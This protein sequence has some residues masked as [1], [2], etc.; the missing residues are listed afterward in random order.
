[1]KK[2][3][4]KYYAHSLEDKPPE[5]WQLLEDHLRNVARL[6]GEFA[7]S[8]GSDYWAELAGLWHDIGK[9]SREFQKK[10]YDANGIE[11]YLETKPGK[12][13]HSQAGGHLAQQCMSNGMERIF[14]WLIMGHHAGLADFSSDKTG[15]KALEPKM[16]N[17]E[18]SESILENV[19]DKI[20][21][22]LSPDFP[23]LLKDGADIS[24]FI[25]ILFSCVVDAD[26]LDTEAFMNSEKA[27]LRA[28]VY[29]ALDDLLIA[30]DKHLDDLCQSAEP[31]DVNRIRAEVLE[32]CRQSADLNPA[33]FTLTVPTGGGKT[34]SSL[35]FALRHAKKQSKGR[36]IYVIPYTS[37]IEQTA[38]VFRKIPGFENA[39]LEHHCN[40][41][42][43]DESKESIRSRLASENWDAPIIVTTAVQFFESLFACKTSRCRKLHN[44]THSVIIF[45]EAQC[46]PP[47][48]LRPVVFA[49]RELYRHYGVTPVLCTATQPVLTQTKQFDFKF[50]EGFDPAEVVPIISN[51]ETLTDNLKRVELTNHADLRPVSYDELV[52]AIQAENQS[53]LCIVNKKDDCRTLA[54]LLPEEYTLHLSTNMCAAHRLQTIENI[55]KRLKTE[56]KPLYVVSTSLVEAG[57][58]LD[59]PVVY[60]ALSGLD[61]IAQAAGRC[62]REGRLPNYG[63]TVIFLPEKQPGYVQAPASLALEYLLKPDQLK[64]IFLPKTIESYFKQRF[65]QLGDHALDEKQILRL[66]G[67]NLDFYFRTVAER[68]RLIDDDW[69]LPVI[70]PYEEAIFFVDE[71]KCAPHLNRKIIRKLQRYLV[72]ISCKERILLE[73]EGALELIS[74]PEIFQLNA[75]FYDLKYGVIAEGS[76]NINPEELIC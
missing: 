41:V 10:L 66:L 47:S 9:Y 15:A 33:V 74:L 31:T 32:Q 2:S 76:I 70:A 36:I 8:F 3:K 69:Q 1:M 12:V 43:N 56:A 16:R 5:E 68:F 23:Q 65:F 34:L 44:I 22:K 38:Q 19:P 40:V 72:N 55:R 53:V 59:F 39:V 49:I 42:S 27:A 75:H 28:E 50:K 21:N 51:P 11:C 46:L 24:F 62:N 35:A 29:P 58:D 67:G 52:G 17:P 60:R 73:R 20:K 13:I 6:A 63:K 45:D 64:T 71:L 48:Y 14:C 30:L 57:V 54:K 18:R 25:R 37:I 26:F 7:S 61:S 4:P